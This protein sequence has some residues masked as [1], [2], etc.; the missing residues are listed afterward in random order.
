MKKAHFG[1]FDDDEDDESEEVGETISFMRRSYAK[2]LTHS[3]RGRRA[4]PKLCQRLLRKVKCIRFVRC[5]AYFFPDPF[6]LS[7]L[8]GSRRR[9]KK[10]TFGMS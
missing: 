9:N 2:P 6:L 10:K 4:K 1:G 8:L 7:R 5:Y 3:P